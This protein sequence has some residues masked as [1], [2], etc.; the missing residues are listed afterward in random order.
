LMLKGRPACRSNFFI[1]AIFL[2]L[3]LLDIGV[4]TQYS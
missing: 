2:S 3:A 4:M 1:F